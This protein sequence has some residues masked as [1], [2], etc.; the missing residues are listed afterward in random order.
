MIVDPGGA[1]RDRFAAHVRE[2]WGGGGAARVEPG[3]AV[4]RGSGSGMVAAGCRT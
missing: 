2:S 3:T 4:G 1:V